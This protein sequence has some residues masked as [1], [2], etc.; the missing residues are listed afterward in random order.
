MNLD[1]SSFQEQLNSEFQIKF[2]TGEFVTLE[3][4]EVKDLRNVH[5]ASRRAFS[6]VFQQHDKSLLLPQKMYFIEHQELGKL[7]LFMVP[8]AN[9]ESGFV[10]EVIFN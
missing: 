7:A 3:L 4:T 9:H 1:F 5:E 10:Y 8:I 2:E 6:L